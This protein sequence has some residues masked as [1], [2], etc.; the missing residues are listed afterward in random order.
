MAKDTNRLV[1]VALDCLV[2][3]TI[4]ALAQ[5]GPIHLTEAL[6]LFLCFPFH[7]HQL[8]GSGIPQLMWMKPMLEPLLNAIATM[9]D[10]GYHDA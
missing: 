10:M 4:V 2:L 8:R 3:Y 7:H 9:V 6:S 5:F 1:N